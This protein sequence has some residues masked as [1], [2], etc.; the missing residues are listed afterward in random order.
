MAPLQSHT[1]SKGKDVQVG[2]AVCVG[3][4]EC[5]AW[6]R[7]EVCVLRDLACHAL[8]TQVCVKSVRTAQAHHA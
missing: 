2:V 5:C 4:G 8:R 7:D 3:Q 1:S 6:M